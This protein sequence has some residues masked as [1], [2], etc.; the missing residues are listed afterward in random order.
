MSFVYFWTRGITRVR[1]QKYFSIPFSKRKP[2]HQSLE[3]WNFDFDLDCGHW[4]CVLDLSRGL[5]I[6][7]SNNVSTS[8][9]SFRAFTSDSIRMKYEISLKTTK[10]VLHTSRGCSDCSVWRVLERCEEDT[11]QHIYYKHDNALWKNVLR[12]AGHKK[13]HLSKEFPIFYS[14]MP[15]E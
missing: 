10:H 12:M 11:R 4:P 6:V 15:P 7:T 3:F 2:Y 8:E 14:M 1:D 9:R 5:I 13:G